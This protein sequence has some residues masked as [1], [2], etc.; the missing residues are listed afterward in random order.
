MTFKFKVGDKVR[1]RKKA[2]EEEICRVSGFFFECHIWQSKKTPLEILA[3][4]QA[5]YLGSRYEPEVPIY[6]CR[7][8]EGND[9]WVDQTGLKKIK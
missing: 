1:I 2:T 6:F 3:V 9:W 5:S 8:P 7:D 4:E